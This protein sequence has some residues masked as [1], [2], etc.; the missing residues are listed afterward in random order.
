MQAFFGKVVE[1]AR[2]A[3][4]WLDFTLAVVV[5]AGEL[6][7]RRNLAHQRARGNPEHVVVVV[8]A[9]FAQERTGLPPGLLAA[10]TDRHLRVD[11]PPRTLPVLL[12]LVPGPLQ[13]SA[14]ALPTQQEATINRLSLQV[15]ARAL[16]TQQESTICRQQEL[17]ATGNNL[18]LEL[19]RLEQK[20]PWYGRSKGLLAQR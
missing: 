6:R 2:G 12:R 14:R 8:S 19:F 9:D 13:V 18:C 11:P 10:V 15:S 17:S 20:W 16:P 1:A 7:N 5:T 4:L 3:Q